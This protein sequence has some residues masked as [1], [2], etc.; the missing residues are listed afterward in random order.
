ML[1]GGLWGNVVVSYGASVGTH[2]A[3]KNGPGTSQ[4]ST[5]SCPARSSCAQPTALPPLFHRDAAETRLAALQ[6]QVTQLEGELAVLRSDQAALQQVRLPFPSLPLLP[7][8][9][10]WASLQSALLCFVPSLSSRQIKEGGKGCCPALRSAVQ[11]KPP[12]A[13]HFPPFFPM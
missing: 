2:I 1:G 4:N 13:L 3:K 5:N 8:L 10:S 11:L 6:D 7:C 12:L 9:H